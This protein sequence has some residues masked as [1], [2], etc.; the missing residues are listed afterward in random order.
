[1]ENKTHVHRNLKLKAQLGLGL[2][3]ND[4][5]TSTA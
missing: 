4:E 2:E 1:M 3:F 5:I